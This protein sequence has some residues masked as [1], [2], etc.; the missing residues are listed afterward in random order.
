MDCWAVQGAVENLKQAVAFLE[1]AQDVREVIDAD[2]EEMEEGQQVQIPPFDV[3]CLA[4]LIG[5]S[6][7]TGRRFYK[8]DMAVSASNSESI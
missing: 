3:P 6:H 7:C 5:T 8:Y 1:D 4:A 2:L